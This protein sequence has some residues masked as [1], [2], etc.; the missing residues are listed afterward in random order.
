MA[1][2][3][4]GTTTGWVVNRLRA[5]ILLLASLTPLAAL[6][7]YEVDCYGEN[8]DTGAAVYGTC[9]DG[10]FY[11]QD[12]ETDASVSGYC[13]I[14]DYVQATDNDTEEEV[15]GWCEDR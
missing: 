10:A 2:T 7:H 15:S 1:H 12:S 5:T 14:G 3:S 4:T 8:D 11:G 6:A 9:E 13:E